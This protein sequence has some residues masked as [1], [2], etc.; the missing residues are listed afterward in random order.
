LKD[1]ILRSDEFKSRDLNAIV[2]RAYREAFGRDPDS[3]GLSTYTRALSRGETE[4]E[5]IAELKR[6]REG[7]DYQ[8]GQAIT[9]AYRD[10][11]KRDP[12]AA[13]METYRR[14]VRDKA[15]D[16][17]RIRDAL[18]RSDEYKNLHSR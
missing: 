2:R 1:A 15:Y 17:D 3:S 16:E 14:L 7:Q 8:I 11:L 10:V 13:G 12:D 6:S 5:L 18:R 4:A 9:R